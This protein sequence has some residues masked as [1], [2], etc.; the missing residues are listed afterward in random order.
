VKTD[1][2]GTI[3]K[4]KRFSIHD[5]PGIRTSV[6]LKGCP[7]NCIWCH[8][9]EGISSDIAIWHD[10]SL[11]I[12]CGQCVKACPNSALKLSKSPESIINIDRA[13]CSLSGDCVNGCP[14]GAIQFT[15]YK[16]SVT[17]IMS[18]IKKDILYYNKS[19]GGMTL[20]GGEPLYQPEF[21]IEILK[22]CKENNIL[23]AIE[24]C[25]FCEKETID[26]ISEFVD[27][28]IIDMKI[29][30]EVKHL[31]FT[32]KSNEII[33]EN[34]RHIAKSGKDILVRIPMIKGLTDTEENLSAIDE[35]VHGINKLIPVEH[36][37][38]NPLAE[39]NYKKLGIPFMI[40]SEAKSALVGIKS[41]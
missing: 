29:Y 31:R 5:G 26:R 37:K 33:K 30:D 9:P 39:N 40:A 23:T 20:T 27:L 7:L 24:S 25:L 19:A 8:S 14:T 15:G 11:C 13:L 6:F 34:F 17:D 3:F 32:G 41:K 2:T 28:F 38:Y 10:N 18:E 21:S 4:I 36:I 16:I 22:A 1:I 35:F 12:A